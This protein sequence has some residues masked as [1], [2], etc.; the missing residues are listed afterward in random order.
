[1]RGLSLL[2]GLMAIPAAWWAARVI[3]DSTRAAWF[4]AILTAF[5][6][7]LAQ[8]AQEAR[9]YSLVALL[10]I[11]ATACFLRA[12]A[13]DDAER[14]GRG[15]RASRSR[16]RSR[17]TRTTGRS[18]SPPARRSA[19][20]VLWK[21]APSW[22]RRE[23]VRDG[24]LGFGGAFVL[25]L[26]WVPTTLYQAA[27]TGAPWSDQP[28]FDSLLGVPGVLLGRMPQIVLLICAGAGL[29]ALLQRRAAALSDK[30]RVGDRA[31]DPRR[32]HAAAGLDAVAGLARLGQPLPRGR[33]GAVPAAR[34][35]RAR[36]RAPARDRRPACWS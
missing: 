7:F 2:F 35:G 26:P 3:W 15:S 8:Y 11:P 32:R 1:M 34:R 9:M 30:G 4:A 20:A 13:L 29:L 12:Y 24:L 27:H 18:S 25:Y 16:S 10:A 5:N 28:A 33:A 17:S 31:D 6:P 23:L 36:A 19:W 21:L 22:R 14:G